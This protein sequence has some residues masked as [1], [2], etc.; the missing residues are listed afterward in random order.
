M[1]YGIKLEMWKYQDQTCA[2]FQLDAKEFFDHFSSEL[3]PEI[4]LIG[5]QNDI[6]EYPTIC[7]VPQTEEIKNYLEELTK[8]EFSISSN[9]WPL[10]DKIKSKFNDIYK[11][12]IT[13]ISNPVYLKRHNI[14]IV[15]QLDKSICNSIFLEKIIFGIKVCILNFIVKEFFDNIIPIL[16]E[17]HD[18]MYVTRSIIPSI[19]YMRTNVCTNYVSKI[20]SLFPEL[21]SNVYVWIFDK[22]S[23]LQYE[24]NINKGSIL[25]CN[26]DHKN[27]EIIL[28]FK[29]RIWLKGT[30]YRKI[31]KLLEI[32]NNDLFLYGRGRYVSGIAK[33][34]NTDNLKN[35]DLIFIKFLGLNTWQLIH[36]ETV[37]LTIKD[38]KPVFDKPD[39]IIKLFYDLLPKKFPSITD[40]DK[41][42]LWDIINQCKNQKKGTLIII[43]GMADKESLR[44]KNDSIYLAPKFIS[45]NIYKQLSS[46]DGAILLD[47]HGICHS[48]G[49]IL[50]GVSTISSDSGR[51]SRYNSAIRYVDFKPDSIA[52]IISEDGMVDLYPT[53]PK[54]INKSEIYD[55]IELLQKNL[56]VVK[57]DIDSIIGP[58]WGLNRYRFYLSAEQCNTVNKCIND[59]AEKYNEK[60]DNDFI[61]SLN[62]YLNTNFHQNTTFKYFELNPHLN[63]TFFID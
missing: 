34:Q 6:Q 9:I 51:G 55:L 4:L 49:V 8:D 21:N 47:I 11:D 18:E 13:F 27:I 26:E 17:Q 41:N 30:E 45:K 61:T 48:I 5:L 59:Y 28:K 40:K 32:T 39:T 22:L 25:I 62:K 29:E 35:D 7:T 15:L 20:L 16:K 2:R 3:N 43:S 46:I 31:R 36:G 14:L 19:D 24:K 10:C 1:E 42:T 44:L 12:K 52:V 50:D 37:M 60:F 54:K 38:K 57:K 33:I 58:I 56:L 53:L 63:D 23:S